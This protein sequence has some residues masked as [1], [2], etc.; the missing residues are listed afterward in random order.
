MIRKG[1]LAATAA[2]LFATGTAYADSF[3]DSQ[4]VA[5]AIKGT[6]NIDFAT[7]L[8]TDTTGKVPE[9]SPVLGAVDT[10]KIDLDVFNSI[11]MKGNIARRPW[12]PT[13][14]L[15][16]TAQEGFLVYDIDL[17]L[18]NPANPSQQRTIGKWAGGLSL[19][20]KGVYSLDTP[21]EGKGALRISVDSINTIQGF[22]S[23]FGGRIQ[24]RV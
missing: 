3:T 1:L 13:A 6:M 24:G 18:K 22:T 4:S 12:L 10:Y 8:D 9:G 7:R 14:T 15:G 2:L 20:G 5:G 23:N 16:V 17:G 11:V 19:D 21:P